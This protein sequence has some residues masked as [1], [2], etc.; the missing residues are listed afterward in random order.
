MRARPGTAPC[1]RGPWSALASLASA[2]TAVVL[3]SWGWVAQFCAPVSTAQRRRT[4]ASGPLSLLRGGAAPTRRGCLHEMSPGRREPV[5]LLERD[6]RRPDPGPRHSAPKAQS[7]QR[8]PPWPVSSPA[9]PRPEEPPAAQCR[10][11]HPVPCSRALVG[12]TACTYRIPRADIA[13][14]YLLKA[15]LTNHRV[16]QKTGLCSWTGE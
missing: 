1:R 6:N 5:H 8:T 10:D 7:R 14:A 4:R 12:L 3:V 16:E 13:A 15:G 11:P 2:H 9:A